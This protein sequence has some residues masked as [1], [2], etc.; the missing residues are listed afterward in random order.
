[1]TRHENK[2]Q[3]GHFCRKACIYVRQSTIT[4]VQEHQESTRRQYE[5]Y[6]R[7]RQLG[8]MEAQIEIIDEDLGHSASDTS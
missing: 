5:M 7:A 8:W 4:Q 1:M 3:E 6:Q 2:I